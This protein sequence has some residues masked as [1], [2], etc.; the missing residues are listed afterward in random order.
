MA[1]RS[2]AAERFAA[3][4]DKQPDGGCW[5]WKGARHHWQ[6]K[7]WTRLTGTRNG[8]A[9]LTPDQ[10]REIRALADAGPINKCAV[11]RQYG[12]SD[13]VIYN[14]VNRKSWRDIA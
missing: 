1:R 2:P 10:V 8:R 12:V 5:L 3:L 7:P 11:G 9:K 6:T 4:I 14:V 13:L